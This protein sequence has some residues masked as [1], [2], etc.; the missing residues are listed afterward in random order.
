MSII[1]Q[2][3][4]HL[5]LVLYKL[6]KEVLYLSC[7]FLFVRILYL[8]YQKRIICVAIYMFLFEI[9]IIKSYVTKTTLQ[10]VEVKLFMAFINFCVS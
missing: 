9:E 7:L 2:P 3:E 4:Y 1:K 10:T 8:Y 6:S 5:R